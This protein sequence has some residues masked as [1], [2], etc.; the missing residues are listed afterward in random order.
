MPK[1]LLGPASEST[2]PGWYGKIPALGDFASRR[3]PPEFLNPWEEWLMASLRGSRAALADRWRDTFLQAPIWRFLL[4][5]EVCGPKAWTGILMPSVDNVGR[6]FPLTVALSV[7]LR[8]PYFIALFS[9]LSLFT[10]LDDTA[11]STLNLQ[12]RVEDFEDRLKGISFDISAESETV[13]ASAVSLHEA[14]QT[15]SGIEKKNPLTFEPPLFAKVLGEVA[16]LAVVPQFSRKSL[17][18]T[19]LSETS[20]LIA[21][22]F[23]GLPS[24]ATFTTM[25]GTLKSETLP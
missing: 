8:S 19:Q 14:W 17:W 4:F 11:R 5:P 16:L 24:T 21:H 25:L 3:L 13:R 10:A 7:P 6:H 12:A 18:W 23:S 15:E 1:Q 2:I 22:A 20:S 9:D